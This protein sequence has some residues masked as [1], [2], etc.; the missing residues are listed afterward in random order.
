[1]L[2]APGRGAPAVLVHEIECMGDGRGAE[3]GR[4]VEAVVGSD[5]L[6]EAGELLG[7]GSSIERAGDLQ[8]AVQ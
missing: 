1:M 3:P 7:S 2:L 4:P 6:Q 5:F 8:R